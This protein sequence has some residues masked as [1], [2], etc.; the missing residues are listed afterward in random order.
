MKNISLFIIALLTTFSLSAQAPQMMTYQSVI[1]DASDALV[2]NTTIGIQISILQGSPTGLASYIETHSPMTNVNGLATLEIGN[3]TPVT[4]S[5][6]GIDWSNGPYYLKTEIDPTGGTAYTISGTN[7]LLSVPYALYAETS[8]SGSGSETDPVFT[9][10]PAGGI[11]AGDITN[12]NNDLVDDADADPNNELQTLSINGQDL[13]ISSGNTVTLPSGGGGANTLD[14]AYDEGGAGAG[15]II[16][17]DA[18]AV[19]VNSS[20]NSQA[21]ISASHTGNGVSIFGNNTSSATQFSTIQGSTASS[22]NLVS[23]VIGS[24]TGNAWGVSGQVSNTATAEAAVYGNN[25]RTNGGYGVKGL[26]Y[27][28]VWGL[29]QQQTGAGTWGENLNANGTGLIGIGNAQLPQVLT[30]G[31][32]G[33]FLGN[34]TGAFAKFNTVGVGQGITI[35]DDFGAQWVVGA[36][37]GIGYRKISGTGTVNTIV[38][39]LNENPVM[40]T[41]PEAPEVL[42]QDFGEGQLTNGECI[43]TID[44]ILAKNIRVDESHPLRVFITLEGDC[45]GVF[46][47]EK[48]Q[49]GFK[50]KELAGGTSNTNFTYQV[51]ANRADEQ[52]P[53]L[54]E[55]KYSEE[56]WSPATP[57]F[58]VNNMQQGNTEQKELSIKR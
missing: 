49:N 21:A 19:E 9:S 8:G 10:S 4:G 25:L 48:S 2:A 54:K 24:S 56:R 36:W 26:G 6:S 42:F 38:P 14:Q 55:S 22:S 30:A 1:R 50:V 31:S 15:R 20:V 5:F 53:G 40:M 37:D 58:D 7:Q 57:L 33:A 18:G 47:T 16:T 27:N 12:W 39:D 11:T 32:G 13:T 3:G 34:T 43:I 29:S 46:V 52:L 41:A 28:G 51:V 17:A 45:N 35:Q 44:P 23:G